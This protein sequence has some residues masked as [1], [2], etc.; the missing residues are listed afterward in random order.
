MYP[1]NFD[2]D[3]QKYYECR[4]HF[5]KAFIANNKSEE[6]GLESFFDYCSAKAE[7][8]RQ[9]AFLTAI[10]PF[11]M[12]VPVKNKYFLH[13]IV[14]I[15]FIYE[16]GNLNC[17]MK[18]WFRLLVKLEELLPPKRFVNLKLTGN[19]ISRKNILKLLSL[20]NHENIENI[21]LMVNNNQLD[22]VQSL[23]PDVFND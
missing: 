6:I 9:R 2:E 17:K 15:P 3:T 10:F 21:M 14:D 11:K 5:A 7:Y 18:D 19:V 16:H 1:G 13:K 22:I 12:Y 23:F 20:K 8:Y 4:D